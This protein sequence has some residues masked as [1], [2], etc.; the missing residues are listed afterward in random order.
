MKLKG[1]QII[2]FGLPRFDASIESTNYT[3]AKL[4][5]RHNQVYYVENPFT[6]R[7]YFKMRK[8]PEFAVRKRHFQLSDSSLL[9]TDI[10]NL[11]IVIPPILLSVNFL[12]ENKFFRNLLKINE[13]LIRSK[14]KTVIKAH[15][16]A[17]FIFINSFNFHYPSVISGLSPVLTVYH[18]LDPMVLPFNRRHGVVS[19]EI[20]VKES[21][22]VICSSNQLYNEK[23]A[24]NPNTY[25]VA[26]A[27]DIAHSSKALDPALR[28]HPV[29]ASIK[30]PVIG[31]L[32]AIERRLDYGLLRQVISKNPDKSFVFVGP[33]SPEF[34]P[35]W[36]NMAA[37]VHFT[38]TINYEDM[39]AVI[40]GFDV[41]LIPFKKDDFSSSIFPLKLFEYLGAG[42]PVVSIDFNP[43][44]KEF[45]KG[46]VVFCDTPEHF[47]AAIN[48][49]LLNDHDTLRR[50]R[51]AIAA[52]N[53][54]EKRVEAIGEIIYNHLKIKGKA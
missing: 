9:D 23:K 22:V 13:L 7:D 3:T 44:L 11:K 19:E 51:V 17:D 46:G 21:D 27:A 43:D 2:I 38:G 40:K 45:T 8:W 28:V 15:G 33:V 20:L 6:V 26:N 53:T 50:E 12:P 48:E 47:S 30:R 52:E 34:V 49:A 37:N 24:Q 41:A 31:Y 16:I 5:A 32:G 42:K 29:I 4:L 25:F 10:P 35:E 18:C 1:H 36:F 14:L 39:P 54:W